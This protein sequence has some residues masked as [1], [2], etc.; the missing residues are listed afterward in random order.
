VKALRTIK[1][2]ELAV[3]GFVVM[4]EIFIMLNYGSDDPAGGVFIGFL[5]TFGSVVSG[6]A[7]AM[8]EQILQ[9]AVTSENDLR[10]V[11]SPR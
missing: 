11:S 3:I 2:C 6:A 1:Y 5:I 4:E 10:R 8:F 7:A 9:S